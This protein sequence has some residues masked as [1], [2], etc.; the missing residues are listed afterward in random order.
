[1]LRNPRRRIVLCYLYEVSSAISDLYGNTLTSTTLPS[2]QNL[3]DTSALLVDTTAPTST[4]T[5]VEYDST[6]NQIVL[7]GTKFTTIASS[8]TDVKSALDWSKLV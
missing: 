4:I 2:G 5:G 6:N 8:G 3:S 1:M 7:T